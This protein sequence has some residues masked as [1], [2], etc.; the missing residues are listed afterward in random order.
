MAK[1]Y[2][3]QAVFDLLKETMSANGHLDEI[4]VG[5]FQEGM[6]C[7]ERDAEENDLYVVYDAQRGDRFGEKTCLSAVH[8]A[9]VAIRK[10]ALSRDEILTMEQSFLDGLNRLSGELL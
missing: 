9:M 8:A 2:L 1:N 3:D 7:I 10:V 5:G 4:N 6:T